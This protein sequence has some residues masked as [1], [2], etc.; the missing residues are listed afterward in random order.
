[1][2]NY[3]PYIMYTTILTYMHKLDLKY[4]TLSTTVAF[5]EGV[6]SSY[7]MEP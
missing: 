2:Y 4:C 3:H 7:I 1:M 5:F 6:G